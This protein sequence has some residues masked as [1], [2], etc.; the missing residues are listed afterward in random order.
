MSAMPYLARDAG[1]VRRERVVAN[2]E[3][4]VKHRA[5][6]RVRVDAP[7]QPLDVAARVGIQGKT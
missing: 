5:H 6:A 7:L 1:D 3:H 2:R 4:D